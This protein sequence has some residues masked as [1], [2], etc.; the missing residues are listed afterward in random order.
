[1]DVDRTTIRDITGMDN[2]INKPLEI[3]E[4]KPIELTKDE[5]ELKLLEK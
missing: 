4:N 1:M 5:E 3:T 2:S